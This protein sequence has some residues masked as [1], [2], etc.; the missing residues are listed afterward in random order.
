M[1]APVEQGEET[2]GGH[3]EN[4]HVAE[5]KDQTPE[6]SGHPVIVSE[7]GGGVGGVKGIAVVHVAQEVIQ[8]LE[9]AEDGG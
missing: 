2:E 6:S 5:E 7:E 1:R 9:D 8:G 3:R 4:E